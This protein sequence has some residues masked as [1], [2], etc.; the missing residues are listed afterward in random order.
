MLISIKKLSKIFDSGNTAVGGEKGTGK[1]VLCGNIVSRWNRPYISN[2]DYTQ[3]ERFI[4]I[5]F[6]KL[7]I[8]NEFR[9]FISGKVNY[10]KFPYPDRTNIVL[11]DSGVYFPCQ[12]D[13][14]LTEEFPEFAYFQ[15]LQRQIAD[16]ATTCNSQDIERPWLKIREQAQKRFFICDK[17]HVLFGDQ[18]KHFAPFWNKLFP[19]HKWKFNG[20]VIASLRFY[21]REQ[22]AIDNVP[23]FPYKEPLFKKKSDKINIE[24]EKAKYLISY[25]K[26]I[27]YTYI[28]INKSKHNSRYFR[29]LLLQGDP[30]M[31]Y[32]TEYFDEHGLFGRG[33]KKKNNKKKGG[34]KFERENE[35]PF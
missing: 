24:L 13:K 17:C 29:D 6:D 18:G 21:E 30:S 19:K 15:A 8:H 31:K 7:N 34:N 4:M 35:L 3:D 14:S 20:I 16:A 11:S 26:I 25:G 9:N 5:D 22:S 1:D 2:L 12:E 27:K 10:Y 32:T 33:P 23:P 28:C